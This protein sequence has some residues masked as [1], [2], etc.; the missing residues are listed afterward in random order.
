VERK[1]VSVSTLKIYVRE[2][3]IS[4]TKNIVRVALKT[5]PK[6]KKQS[7]KIAS[8]IFGKVLIETL[9]FKNR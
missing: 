4:D 2:R 7:L 5:S 3:H 6:Q 1:N 8:T 9:T